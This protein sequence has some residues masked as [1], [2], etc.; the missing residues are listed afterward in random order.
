LQVRRLAVKLE[1]R[2]HH[3]RRSSIM[4][5][6]LAA[7]AL[8]LAAL[9]AH[10]VA[11]PN[12]VAQ[13]PAIDRALPAS[14]AAIRIASHGGQMNALVYLPA[15]KGPHPVAILLHGFP[16][17]EQNLDLAQAM[18]RAGWAV[19]TFHYRGSWGSEGAFSFDGAV[20]DGMAVFDW[21]RASK[22][23]AR[24]R[25]D[26]Q[27]VVVVGHSMGGYVAA[28]VCAAHAQVL[29]CGLIAPWDLSMDQALMAKQSPAERDH[30]AATELDD[31][32]GRIAGMTARSVVDALAEHGD[33][34][35]LAA[36]ATDLAQRRLLIVTAD[37]DA[38]DCKALQLQPALKSAHASDLR[39]TALPSDHG[40]N[41]QRI[42]LE[43]VV[44]DWLGG[45]PGAPK[46]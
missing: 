3:N 32:D 8:S 2:S 44:L 26:A 31:V 7:V 40:F 17:N 46:P 37:R 4:K 23:D 24:L 25:L 27:R 6:F 13:D 33:R 19:V 1:R 34:W 21:V 41:D 30:T 18:R 42:A 39:T 38:D 20:E 29:G 28:R 36:T 11:T 43:S 35:S 45:L 9:S 14:S 16:G 12:A 22:P 5:A 10:V 15:G